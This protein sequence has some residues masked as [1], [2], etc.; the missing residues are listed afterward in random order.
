MANLIEHLPPESYTILT[1]FYNIDNLSAKIGSWLPGEYV[2][3]DKPS[4]SKQER[5]Q[6]EAKPEDKPTNPTVRI[7]NYLKNSIILGAWVKTPLSAAVKHDMTIKLKRFLKR[8]T[9]FKTLLGAPLIIGQ[10]PFIIKQGVKTVREKNIELIVGF[11]D[12][13]PALVSL[14]YIH[15]KTNKPFYLYMFDIYKGNLLPLTGHILANIFEPRLFKLAEKIIV[16]NKETKD[17]YRRRYGNE[18]AEKIVVIYNSTDPAPFLNFTPDLSNHLAPYSIL[19]TGNVYWAQEGALK[20]LVKAVEGINDLDIRIK[21]Y[22]P[23]PPEYLKAIGLMSS[24]IDLSVA[25]ESEMP[26]IQSGA[27]ILFIC[28]AWNTKSPDIINTATPGKLTNYLVAGRPIL[29]HSPAKSHLTQ[30]A[31]DNNFA[32][33]VDQ[34]DITDLQIAIRKLLT[35]KDLRIQLVENAKKTF[36]ANHDLTKNAQLFR[37]LLSK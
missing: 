5:Q 12:Y 21:L 18:M 2:F 15:K 24:K 20:N 7:K 32:M 34:E 22:T 30:Y 14:Y 9:F 28:L 1:S 10:V 6:E 33:V 19:F 3:Y 17:F 4:A 16:T 36:Y 8:N 25:P 13:G 35:N 37:S 31:M 23:A 11:S 26:K 29:V 27:D